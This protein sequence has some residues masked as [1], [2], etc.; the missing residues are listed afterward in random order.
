VGGAVVNGAY[1]SKIGAYYAPDAVGAVKLAREVL[2][3]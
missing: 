1:A 3:L 2:Q